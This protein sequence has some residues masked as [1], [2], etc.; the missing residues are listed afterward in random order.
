MKSDTRKIT[1]G[2]M[3]VAMIGGLL[4]LDR[5]FAYALSSSFSWVLSIPIIVYSVQTN[6]KYSILVSISALFVGFFVTNIQTLFYLFTALII[7]VVYSEGIRKKWPTGKLLAWTIGLT[8]ISYLLSMYVFAGFFGYDLVATRQEFIDMLENFEFMGSKV[9]FL[10][11]SN[12]LFNV[13]DISS[14]LLIVILESLCVHLLSQLV[15]Y[16][17]K[18]VDHKIT[19][20]LRNF[21]YPKILS[22]LGIVS[23]GAIYLLNFIEMSDTFEYI[24][25]FF[26]LT[27]FIVNFVYGM[28]VLRSMPISKWLRFLLFIIPLFWPMIMVLGI[29]D[30]LMDGKIRKRGN[31]G[32]A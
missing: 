29:V 22:V 24:I 30:G 5:Q 26:Y 14:F 21:R 2:A 16:K 28:I 25:A 6:L 1:E 11:D 31:Y 10:I 23:L 17:L 13:L 15:F 19:I 4:F 32:E 8:F 20:D 3:I 27:L 7:G 9:V 12:T 18:L